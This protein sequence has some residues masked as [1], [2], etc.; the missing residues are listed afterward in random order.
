[1]KSIRKEF[2]AKKKDY[3]LVPKQLFWDLESRPSPENLETKIYKDFYKRVYE[4]IKLGIEEV[5]E[6]LSQKLYNNDYYKLKEKIENIN[7]NTET[8]RIHIEDL[9]KINLITKEMNNDGWSIKQ[10]EGI[11]SG[12]SNYRTGNDYGYGYGY[13]FTDGVLIVWEK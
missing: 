13:N 2:Y 6:I 3:K 9:D 11:Q 5:T 10:I 4:E 7:K 12:I 8:E 1:I